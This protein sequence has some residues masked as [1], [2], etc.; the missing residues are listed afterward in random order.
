MSLA[1][2]NDLLAE[3]PLYMSRSDAALIARAPTFMLGCESRIYNGY[4]D[5][6]D[7]MQ[8]DPL[9]CQLMETAATVAVSAGVAT[10]PSDFLEQRA[11][12]VAGS[13]TPQLDYYAPQRFFG[14][15][16]NSTQSESSAYTIAAG[17]LT[18]SNAFTGN[19]SLVY[20]KQFPALVP[21]GTNALMQAYP[22]VWLYGLMIEAFEWARNDTGAERYLAKFK[23]TVAAANSMARKQRYGGP[24]QMTVRI[25]PIG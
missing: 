5:A 20:Y 7:P 6:D 14:Y 13:G 22:L 8:S 3:L 9:R 17:Q 19:V 11:L 25:D 15:I 4:G 1:S 21:G 2:Y 23:N 24:S 10:L 18:V 12:Y 16:Q